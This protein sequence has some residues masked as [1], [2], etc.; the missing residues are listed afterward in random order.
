MTPPPS[1]NFQTL[2]EPFVPSVTT[3]R[4]GSTFLGEIL[5]SHPDTFYHFEPLAFNDRSGERLQVRSGTLAEQSISTLRSL[6]RC[7]YSSL[8]KTEKHQQPHQV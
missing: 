7:N 6:L 5:A 8:G 2:N 1:S 3:W 4:S